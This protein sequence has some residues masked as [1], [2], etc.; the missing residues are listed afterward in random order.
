M[1]TGSRRFPVTIEED[2]GETRDSDTNEHIPAWETVYTCFADLNPIGGMEYW[3]G[4][5]VRANVDYGIQIMAP[6]TVEIRPDM[7]VVYGNRKFKIISVIN[8][9][10]LGLGTDMLIQA[11][12]EP[13]ET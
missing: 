1:S 8:P 4:Q 10:Q 7:R 13:G 12:E 2:T 5:Q 3:Q 11:K 9:S 6:D